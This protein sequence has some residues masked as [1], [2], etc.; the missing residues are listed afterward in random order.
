MSKYSDKKKKQLE[1]A[2]SGVDVFAVNHSFLPPTNINNHF[3]NDNDEEDVPD[4]D[5]GYVEETKDVIEPDPSTLPTQ[6]IS[7]EEVKPI[8]PP[9]PS[10][11][12]KNLEVPKINNPNITEEQVK[13]I[14]DSFKDG[15][16]K[17]VVTHKLNGK[18]RMFCVRADTIEEVNRKLHQFHLDIVDIVKNNQIQL[19]DSNDLINMPKEIIGVPCDKWIDQRSLEAYQNINKGAYD[20]AINYTKEGVSRFSK[21][22]ANSIAELFNKLRT[23]GIK[24][25]KVYQQCPNN[26]TILKDTEFAFQSQS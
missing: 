1:L 25:M 8:T 12:N 3:Y 17:Y 26:R 13:R 22:R 21:L 16:Y 20:F 9:K 24:P 10:K 6:G 19:F 5:Y 18:D 23:F 14:V 11:K 2:Q 4:N 7:V 15:K